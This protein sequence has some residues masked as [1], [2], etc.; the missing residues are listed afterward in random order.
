M[1]NPFSLTI[2]PIGRQP[3]RAK[4]INETTLHE[5]LS[6][7]HDPNLQLYHNCEELKKVDEKKLIEFPITVNS[8]FYF[9]PEV[10]DYNRTP[11]IQRLVF[12][13]GNKQKEV[14]Q[15]GRVISACLSSFFKGPWRLICQG[16][17]VSF[18]DLPSTGDIYV[19]QKTENFIDIEI[20]GPNLVGNIIFELPK[21]STIADIY[22]RLEIRYGITDKYLFQDGLAVDGPIMNYVDDRGFLILQLL[23]YN[24]VAVNHR[25]HGIQR[26]GFLY[27]N[28]TILDL[29]MLIRSKNKVPLPWIDLYFNG[30]FC[31]DS[32]NVFD[33]IHGEND[34]LELSLNRGE[35][36]LLSINDKAYDVQWDFTITDLRQII[37]IPKGKKFRTFLGV[38]HYDPSITVGAAFFKSDQTIDAWVESEF[39]IFVYDTNSHEKQEITVQPG[40]TFQN[41][42]VRVSAW[43]KIDINSC[44]L[45][46]MGAQM[47]DNQTFAS[48]RIGKNATINL[49]IRK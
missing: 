33:I 46:Y 42:R 28:S 17:L 29:K 41:L 1:S 13:N 14:K 5:I 2:K 12:H 38:Y 32:E 25:G 8:P 49:M 34:I 35:T 4:V 11:T 39:P 20:Y 23:T 47:N 19:E 3:Y 18:R 16:H 44:K 30:S 43:K 21:T 10:V 40:E 9:I 7:L 24:G 36:F 48:C 31:E 22:Q 6:Q 26:Y 45:I 37:G 15:D 27:R